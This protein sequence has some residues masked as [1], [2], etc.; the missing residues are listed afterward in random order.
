MADG[1]GKS[2]LESGKNRGKEHNSITKLMMEG[3]QIVALLGLFLSAISSVIATHEVSVSCMMVYDEGG[4]SAVFGSPECPH[5]VLSTE[6]LRNQTGNCQFATLQGH[7]EYQEDRIT[8]NL[9]MKM[10]FLDKNGTREVMV[11]VAAVFDGHGGEEA[12]EMASKHLLDYFS[13]HFVF[14]T[15]KQALS[16]KEERNHDLV[17]QG[18]D[19]DEVERDILNLG[20]SKGVLPLNEDEP[21]A[22][23]NKYVSG[24]TA[25][26]VLWVDGQ[27]L[28][29]NVGDSK[30][31]L[32]SE[33]IQSPLEAGTS[34]AKLHAEELTRDHH[35]D[36]DDERARIEAAGGFVRMRGVPR[37]NGILALSRSIGDVYLKRYG[38]IAVPEV[39]GWRPLTANDSY[40][41]IASDGIFET[42]TLGDVCDLLWDAN[43]QENEISQ[44]SSSCLSSSLASNIVNTAFKKG[45]SDNL[46]AIVVPLRST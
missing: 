11:S 4:A 42:L 37:V 17:F 8:C 20:S 16:Y 7:R 23:N 38:V 27:I 15:Y 33:R 9:E 26:V 44:N 36:R 45:S 3:L 43:I 18:H 6:S 39:L 28:V 12:S 22:F 1:D 34:M 25:T 21:E 2:D 13:L 24:S 32:C 30:A 41:V 5:W 10:P 46:S 35:P 19:G 29:A 31:L 40:L 14:N